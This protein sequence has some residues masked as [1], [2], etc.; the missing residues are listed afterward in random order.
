MIIENINGTEWLV[1]EV[2]RFE[3]DTGSHDYRVC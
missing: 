2:I 3:P 1:N